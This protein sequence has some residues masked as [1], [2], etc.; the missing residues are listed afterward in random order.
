MGGTTAGLAGLFSLTHV[1]PDGSWLWDADIPNG[2]T[3]A[4]ADYLQGVA[5]KGV[6]QSSD[7][8]LGLISDAGFADPLDP[9]DTH[10]SH[11][12]WT[13][14]AAGA[15]RTAW[16]AGVPSSGVLYN[17]TPARV[18][19]ASAGLIR[20]V[21]VSNRVA[22]GSLDPAGVLYAT[23]AAAGLAVVAGG[24]LFVTYGVT[25]KDNTP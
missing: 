6:G 2:V 4:G 25:A 9:A 10:G 20:G 14:Y 19:V 5:F 8:R 11:P 3:L 22:V 18:A 23:A 7:W 21:F 15:S 17:P 24:T 1:G 12:H 16:G 13:E